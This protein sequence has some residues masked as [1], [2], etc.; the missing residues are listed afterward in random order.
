MPI[1]E[2]PR[3]AADAVGRVPVGEPLTGVPGVPAVPLRLP[4]VLRVV[5]L[6]VHGLLGVKRKE[7]AARGLVPQEVLDERVLP[8][9]N[10][11]LRVPPILP[12]VQWLRR[13]RLHPLQ[14]PWAQ[15]VLPRWKML[16]VWAVSRALLP[17]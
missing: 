4:N 15:P 2:L 10:K 1:G 6:G 14:P 13:E 9:G 8:A 11:L 17:Q 12:A 3:A 7:F 16:P 5:I